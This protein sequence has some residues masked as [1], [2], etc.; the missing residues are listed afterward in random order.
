MVRQDSLTH[1]AYYEFSLS[2]LVLCPS[3]ILAGCRTEDGGSAGKQK[4]TDR[5]GS[6]PGVRNLRR[7]TKTKYVFPRICRL[8]VKV[9]LHIAYYHIHHASPEPY[10]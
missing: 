8:S 4:L 2:V 9:Q 3:D 1:R 5:K 10:N 7:D 6:L